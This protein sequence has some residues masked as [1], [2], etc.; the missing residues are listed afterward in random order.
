MPRL[1]SAPSL[2]EI[3]TAAFEKEQF[4][5]WIDS[6][7]SSEDSAPGDWEEFRIDDEGEEEDDD[8]GNATSGADEDRGGRARNPLDQL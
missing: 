8:G 3:T 1:R 5:D 7:D 6:D 4:G 2:D